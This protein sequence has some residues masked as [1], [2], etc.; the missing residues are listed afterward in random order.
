MTIVGKTTTTANRADMLPNS[1][2]LA[3]AR[4]DDILREQLEYL[5]DHAGD[6]IE[7]RC[8]DCRRYLRV[9]S[10]LLQVFRG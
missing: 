3:V 8:S 1:A 9:R 10:L 7:P 2:K 5:I 6:T 4:T